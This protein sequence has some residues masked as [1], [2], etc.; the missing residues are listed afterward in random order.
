MFQTGQLLQTQIEDRLRLLLGQVVAAVADAELFFQPFRARGVVARA[1]QHRGD[2]AQFPGLRHQARFRFCRVRRMTDQ[3]DNRID[4]RQRNRQTFKDMGAIA[5]FAQFKN[6]A[7]RHDFTT[8]THEGFQNLLQGHDLRLALMQRHH[9]DA[10]GDLQ[11]RQR[12][13]VVQHHFRY[14][15][16]LHF[17]YDA[18]AVFVGLVAQ[19]ADAFDTL[20][21]D[22]LGDFLN[23]ARFVDL[24]GNFVND[25]SLAAGFSV[26]FHLA[27]GANVDF[28]ASGTVGLFNAATPVDDGG[29][30]EIGAGDVLH[31]PFDADVF[32]FDIGQA[33][34]DHLGEVMRRNI[35]GHTDGD[36]RRAVNQQ[37]GNFGRQDFGNLLGAVVV[38][39]EIDGLF[40]QIRQQLVGNF[41]HAH[42]GVTHRRG[43]VAVDGTKVALAIHQH[44][45]QRERLGHT[46][47]GVVDGGVAVRVIFTDDVAN[48]T[49]R[50]FVRFVPVVPQH[51]HSIKHATMDRL[52]AIANIW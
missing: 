52:Q 40:L 37:V 48:D 4:I 6:G 38:R 47:D 14:R 5:R 31:Q 20:V 35:S 8:M 50:F 34:V 51:A 46:N 1:L 29:G 26:G 27:A 11:L 49:G 28:T 17:D 33:A 15:V 32:V 9:V 30:R 16:A 24:I 23:Q 22:Q 3:L 10:E 25:D 41:R 43:R 45:A 44:I 18:H 13:E 12:V 7:A 19:R 2:V 42:F 39:H 21:F 36:A